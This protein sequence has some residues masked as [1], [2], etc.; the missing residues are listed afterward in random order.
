[1]PYSGISKLNQ[2]LRE[3]LPKRAQEI[4]VEAY[5]DAY[6]QYKDPAKR[7]GNQSREETARRVAWAAVGKKYHKGDDG[8]WHRQRT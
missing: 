4:Y 8:K 6:D 2:S 1:M 5:N 7:R 3:K